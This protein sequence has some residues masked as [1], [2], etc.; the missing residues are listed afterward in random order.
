MDS[1]L[2]RKQAFRGHLRF[3]KRGSSS[4]QF[5]TRTGTVRKS[6]KISLGLRNR[7]ETR[8]KMKDLTQNDDF[9][10][11]SR[12]KNN[13]GHPNNFGKYLLGRG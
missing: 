10:R 2:L 3:E 7:E 12:G 13:P 11:T 5:S 1:S 4:V 6:A 8:S 9:G